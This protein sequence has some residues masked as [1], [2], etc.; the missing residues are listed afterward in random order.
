MASFLKYRHL[1]CW[2]RH[3]LIIATLLSDSFWTTLSSR[4]S[5]VVSTGS[6]SVTKQILWKILK[7]SKEPL[8]RQFL[9]ESALAWKIACQ[10]PTTFYHAPGHFYSLQNPDMCSCGLRL[11]YQW[12]RYRKRKSR[13]CNIQFHSDTRQYFEQIF[14]KLFVFGL[15]LSIL[16]YIY[17][18]YNIT[19]NWRLSYILI[20]L[21]TIFSSRTIFLIP[22]CT[23]SPPPVYYRV[24]ISRHH[25]STMR[26]VSLLERIRT[27]TKRLPHTFF[28]KQNDCYVCRKID[29]SIL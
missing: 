8:Q 26:F 17:H 25:E 27:Y 15:T 19:V 1:G 23:M 22:S 10:W 11:K 14:Q 12:L 3:T 7:N 18:L 29:R 13:H 6:T 16:F 5:H 4:I 20:F 21:V 24:S 28:L 2:V 9:K